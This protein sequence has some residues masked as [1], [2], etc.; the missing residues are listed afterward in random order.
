M[1]DEWKVVYKRIYSFIVLL[2]PRDKKSFEEKI[3]EHLLGKSKKFP[4]PL[5]LR[6]LTCPIRKIVLDV[7]IRTALP[8]PHAQDPLSEIHRSLQTKENYVLVWKVFVE[9]LLSWIF[10]FL[11]K[12]C[13]LIDSNINWLKKARSR[14]TQHVKG[15]LSLIEVP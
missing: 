1:L 2:N 8:A 9:S 5:T 12:T 4:L 11:R 10:Y 7:T 14:V 13:F 6:A 3:A 15:S